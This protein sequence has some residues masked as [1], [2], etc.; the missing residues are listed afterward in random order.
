MTRLPRFALVLALALPAVRPAPLCAQDPR[1][2]VP[3]V[4]RVLDDWHAAAAKADEERYFRHFAKGAI[5]LGTDATE[6]WSLEAFRA[7]AHPLFAK[8]KAWTMRPTSRHVVVGADGR[9]AWFHELLD[10]QTLGELRGSGVV[11]N[12]GGA[13]KIALYDVSIPIPNDVS[14]DVVKKVGDYKKAPKAAGPP[15]GR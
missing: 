14:K 1:A 7:Y 9:T 6:Q 13:W 5:F 2:V 3:A 11:V 12:E 4:E 10:T 8:G 15:Q